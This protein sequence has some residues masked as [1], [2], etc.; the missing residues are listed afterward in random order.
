MADI[1]P[2]EQP[3]RP[4]LRLIDLL[5]QLDVQGLLTRLYQAGALNLATI[6]HR[7]QFQYYQALQLTPHYQDH[8]QRARAIEATARRYRVTQTT[9]YR[10]LRLMQQPVSPTDTSCEVAPA[11]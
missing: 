1:T 7:Q 8:D 6:E 2:N 9:V 10:A 5:D 11:L 3:T 4:V